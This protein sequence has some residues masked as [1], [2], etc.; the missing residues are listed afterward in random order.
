VSAAPAAARVSPGRV[1][2]PAVLRRSC[3]C[4]GSGHD[5]EPC[6]KKVKL[7]RKSDDVTVETVPESVSEVLRSPGQPLDLAT[8]AFLEPSFGHD[9]SRV[10]IHADGM[11]GESAQAVQARAYTV[12]HHVAFA[13][14]HYAP[15][16]EGGLRLLS[17]ELAHVVQQTAGRSAPNGFTDLEI[18]SRG[19]PEES[20]ADAM[21][22]QVVDG[23]AV[24]LPRGHTGPRVVLRADPAP[25]APASP[26]P[27]SPAPPPQGK[28]VFRDCTPD[29]EKTIREAMSR[30]L[31]TLDG[32]LS[33]LSARPLS[34]HAQHALFLAF[35]VTDDKAAD[36]TKAAL[37]KIR[38]GLPGVT[39]ECDQKSDVNVVCR[40]ETSAATNL[41]TGVVHLCMGDWD[42]SDNL[43]ENP[44]TLVHE[45]AH[46]FAGAPGVGQDPYFDTTCDESA[47]TEAWG[48]GGRLGKADPLACVVYH[49]AH[50]S[51]AEVKDLKELYSGEAFAGIVQTLPRGPISLKGPEKK[52]AF[53]LNKVPVVGGFTYRWRLYDDSDRHYLMRGRDSDKALD[54]L[55]FTDQASAIIGSKTR[56]LLADR[57]VRKGV[58]ECAARIPGVKG[59]RTASEEKVVRLDVEFKD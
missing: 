12:G 43:K 44:R 33:K 20:Q 46:G 22:A 54:W 21:A 58:I 6:R 32:A 55:S 42:T 39:I 52:P 14:G 24:A 41:I 56:A 40:G 8:R 53:I 36:D 2:A 57:G 23:R 25:P 31:S 49:L 4:S 37:Q 16:S 27:V 11:A 35:R 26:V 9:F 19:A 59:G 17:H 38:D 1:P 45:G 30:A 51:P 18:G 47:G 50:R 3:A 15:S 5:C 10:R 34:D 29:Q 7:R 28:N 13:A 48:P